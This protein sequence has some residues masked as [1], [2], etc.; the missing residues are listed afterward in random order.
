VQGTF[1]LNCTCSTC[2]AVKCISA[3]CSTVCIFLNRTS[4][5]ALPWISYNHS[6][7]L[8]AGVLAGKYS[9]GDHPVSQSDSELVAKTL[10]EATAK[11]LLA[12]YESRVYVSAI[13]F[14]ILQ[15]SSYISIV[16]HHVAQVCACA[17]INLYLM[18]FPF[19][20]LRNVFICIF[21][22][23]VFAP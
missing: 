23:L 15:G 6:L 18:L 10:A 14:C 7:N 9:C 11:T 13:K 19:D 12:V 21:V 22:Q 16:S 8:R 5:T 2:H 1:S 3:A 17:D 4:L 20:H